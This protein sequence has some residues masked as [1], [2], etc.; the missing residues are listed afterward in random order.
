MTCS[1]S[2][3]DDTI[4]NISDLPLVKRCLIWI[5]IYKRIQALDDAY[6]HVCPL[7]DLIFCTLS[8]WLKEPSFGSNS[9]GSQGSIPHCSRSTGVSWHWQPGQ[10]NTS[11]HG[12][13]FFANL[14]SDC[15]DLENWILV[16]F[17]FGSRNL[18]KLRQNL[19]STSRHKDPTGN[20]PKNPPAEANQKDQRFWCRIWRPVAASVTAL[21]CVG[22][23]SNH[24]GP[25]LQY[26][27]QDIG[28]KRI[29]T[30]QTSYVDIYCTIVLKIDQM[31]QWA[32]PTQLFFNIIFILPSTLLKN[33][34]KTWHLPISWAVTRGYL[35]QCVWGLNWEITSKP[36][37]LFQSCMNRM[38]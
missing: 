32:R 28:A 37:A 10:L 38:K 5:D 3:L 27:G 11:H 21:G 20:F 18:A 9:W 25:W 23:C 33:R 6:R 22:V 17:K 24:V 4:R 34:G 7:W 16:S 35:W 12:T 15:W 2:I 19:W 36:L 29:E 14:I 31:S 8:K 1:I 26:I 13:L 30:L